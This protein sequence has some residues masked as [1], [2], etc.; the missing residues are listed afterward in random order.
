MSSIP[1][2]VCSLDGKQ[3]NFRFVYDVVGATGLRRVCDGSASSLDWPKPHFNKHEPLLAG[4][5]GPRVLEDSG[6]EGLDILAISARNAA[7]L[8]FEQILTKPTSFKIVI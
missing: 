8:V 7:F 2:I 6:R 3:K 4:R 5:N 1:T